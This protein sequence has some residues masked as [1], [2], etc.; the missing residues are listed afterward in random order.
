MKRNNARFGIIYSKMATLHEIEKKCIQYKT[1]VDTT[2]T[3]LF[4]N[5]SSRIHDNNDFLWQPWQGCQNKKEVFIKKVST[6]NSN[7]ILTNYIEQIK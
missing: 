5:I 1:Y 3:L 2:H 4:H 7:N 6:T